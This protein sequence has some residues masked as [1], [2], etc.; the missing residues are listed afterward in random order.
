MATL[1][2][3][4]AFGLVVTTFMPLVEGIPVVFHPDPTDVVNVAKLIA[5]YQA[6]IL[7]GTATVLGL[8]A[9]DARVNPLMLESLR[10]VV[11]GGDGT[12]NDVLN[13]LEDPSRV[14]L[15]QLAFG[16][17]NM[18]ARE[19]RIPRDPGALAAL[20][21]RELVDLRIAIALYL[22]RNGLPGSVGADLE[23]YV[24]TRVPREIELESAEDWESVLNWIGRLDGAYFDRGMRWCLE[25]G[26][27]RV[28]DS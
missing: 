15:A 28:R 16:T 23:A 6:T 9:G 3:F 24:L 12:V 14:P 8:Y 19:L 1:P 18:L 5:T 21:E 7:C 10:I 17:A 20:V 22:A 25:R 13:G 26:Y 2:Q 11:A 27:Y 4:H